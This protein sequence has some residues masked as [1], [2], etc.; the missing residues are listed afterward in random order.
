[1]ALSSLDRLWRRPPARDAAPLEIGLVNNMPD[2]ALRTTEL[3]VRDLLSRAA[4]ALPVSLRI[5]SLPE[6]PRTEV[7]RLHASQH[8]EPIAAL[9]GSGIAGLIVTGTEPKAAAIEDEPYWPALARLID[10]AEQHTVS[11]IWSCLASHAAAYRLDGIARRPLGK[12]MF[13]VFEC[14]KA[15]DHP[16]VA[17]RPRWSVP[18]SRHNELPEQALTD[19]G[20]RI[21]SRS[22]EAGVDMF[23]KERESLFVFLQGHP[24]YDATALF[25]EYRR[26]VRRFLA[27][28][29]DAYPELP[30]GYFTDGAAAT[31]LTFRER[32]V[33][34][35]DIALLEQFPAAA[36]GP[37]LTAP[38]RDAATRIYANWL[39]YVAEERLDRR[40]R[41][42]PLVAPARRLLDPTY[43]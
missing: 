3:Q 6:V 18:H 41:R 10:W 2:A 15:A 5:F 8:H 16:L 17:G 32:A 1:M 24:E 31:L 33:R 12:K 40:W 25:G 7:G 13:G 23:I 20:Y 37:Q 39:G 11:T 36:V 14:D 43:A 30:H 9:W 29:N 21:L 42:T 22:P 26:D 19:A 34:E 28:D 27:G 35:R 38:W 4:D